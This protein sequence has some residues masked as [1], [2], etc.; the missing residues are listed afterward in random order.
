MTSPTPSSSESERCA[1]CGE[2]ESQ[3]NH[4]PPPSYMSV[5]SCVWFHS[6]VPLASSESEACD[7]KGC[8]GRFPP[9]CEAH[10]CPTCSEYG[11]HV[12]DH[13]RALEERNKDLALLLAEAVRLMYGAD[14]EEKEDF[15]RRAVRALGRK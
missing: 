4:M 11:S 6:F 5:P 2:T 14:P 9:C 1:R 10:T 3:I 7:C 15:V 13:L 12:K 8:D